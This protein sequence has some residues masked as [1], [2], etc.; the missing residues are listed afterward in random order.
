MV[1]AR[2]VVR[3]PDKK[4]TRDLLDADVLQVG[5]GIKFE[6][7]TIQTKAAGV[8]DPLIIPSNQEW[9]AAV[10]TLA[11]LSLVAN[12]AIFMPFHLHNQQTVKR[13]IVL[14]GATIS[15][16][17][18]VG[19]Y[20]TAGVRKVSSGAIAQSGSNRAQIFDISDTVISAGDYYMA[21]SPQGG[22]ADFT[23]WATADGSTI[24]EQ[25]VGIK[26][27]ASAHPL[28]ANATLVDAANTSVNFLVMSVSLVA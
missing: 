21:L 28:P 18:D 16:T 9:P 17:V 14:N 5:A 13:I 7:G 12:T 19:I 1:E 6:D 11:N 3:S 24:N 27:Q 4:T 20:D 2:A 15:G 23:Q 8:T 22:A 10:G 26:T 25:L